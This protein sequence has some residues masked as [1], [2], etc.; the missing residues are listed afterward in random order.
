MLFFFFLVFTRCLDSN[1][2]TKKKQSLLACRVWRLYRF[3]AHPVTLNS[4]LF[5]E[6][7]SSDDLDVILTITLQILVFSSEKKRGSIVNQNPSESSQTLQNYLP[8]PFLKLLI[9]RMRQTYQIFYLESACKY[10]QSLEL[11]R[12]TI[13]YFYIGSF[14]SI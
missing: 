6:V 13:I 5:V 3:L 1:Q 9:T 11:S 10:T 12:V 8:H 14:D 7:I 2:N 4:D